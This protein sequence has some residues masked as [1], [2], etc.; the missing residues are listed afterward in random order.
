MLVEIKLQKIDNGYLVRAEY[1][2]EIQTSSGEYLDD[3]C[4]FAGNMD[5]VRD[6][7]ALVGIKLQTAQ[8]VPEDKE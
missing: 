2:Y 5:A 7:F 4:H 3:T 8:I 6:L 1:G